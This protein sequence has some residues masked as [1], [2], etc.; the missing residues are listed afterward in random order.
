MKLTKLNKKQFEEILE[1]YPLGKYK[2]SKHITWALGNTVYIVETTKGKIVLKILEMANLEY[3]KYQI[4]LINFLKDRKVPVQRIIKT[5]KGAFFLKYNGKRVL[6]LKFVEGK[7]PYSLSDNLVKNIANKMGLM[8]Q[9]FMKLK[10]YGKH[11]WKKDH[12]FKPSPRKVGKIDGFD[13]QKE[14][15]RLIGELKKIDR[16][17][18][19]KS[20]VHGDCHSVNLLV[21]EDRL[22]AII[23][24][25]DAH[26]D[27]L[28]YDVSTFITHS[29][30]LKPRVNKK[31]IKIFL[32][33][34][35]KKI[36]LKDEEKK[37]LYFFV[38]HRILTVIDWATDQM[39]K[40]KDLAESLQKHRRKDIQRY[41]NFEKISLENFLKLF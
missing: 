21:Q 20:V 18:L 25:D 13:F 32:K 33:E 8:H 4:K 28:L 37:A 6:L 10:L 36:K 2:K 30:V 17:K 31:Q 16:K 26:E 40:H 5:K 24:W 22:R 35:R 39:K 11:V 15:K 9:N 41:R 1:K 38:K 14:E 3:L 29:F 19:R 23:D 27:Y 7:T 12:E 34:Y